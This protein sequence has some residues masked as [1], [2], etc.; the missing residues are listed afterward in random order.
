MSQHPSFSTHSHIISE[1]NRFHQNVVIVMKCNRNISNCDVWKA[2]LRW[3]VFDVVMCGAGGGIENVL[4]ENL[5][6]S[7]I[8][9][10]QITLNYHPV[11]KTN[12]TA[13]PT[14][15][16]V[17][18]DWTA[19]GMRLCDRVW[20]WNYPSSLW[21]TRPLDGVF[22]CWQVVVKN[23]VVEATGDKGKGSGLQC[24]GL[25]DSTI[26]GIAFENV[27]VTGAVAAKSECTFCTIKADAATKPQPKCTG[28]A[29]AGGKRDCVF[30]GVD[31]SKPSAVPLQPRAQLPLPSCHQSAA[32]TLARVAAHMRMCGG[33]NCAQ[34]HAQFQPKA[35]GCIIIYRI[36]QCNTVVSCR[37]QR[38]SASEAGRT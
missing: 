34:F 8:S 1:Q 23:I 15:R 20:F 12:L 17:R 37:W 6:G 35:L 9:G 31:C 2:L 11:P 22:I 19:D 13:T 30:G 14:I 5:Y 4:Y 36:L 10:I 32:S 7:V 18:G 16:N 38:Q 27:T 29:W 25:P 3:S 24:D 26:A 33:Q 28:L 21:L